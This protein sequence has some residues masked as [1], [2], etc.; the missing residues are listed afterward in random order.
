MNASVRA[1]ELRALGLRT[2]LFEAGPES[3]EEAVVFIHGGPGSANDWDDLLPRVGTFARAVAFDLPG[4]GQADK[5]ADWWG[6]S[7]AGWANFIGAALN[8]LGVR[9]A[10]LVMHD[11]GGEAACLWA[12]SNP[13]A[14]A[15]GVLINTGVPIGYRWHLIGRLHRIPLLGRVAMAT[16][17][18]GFPVMRLYEPRLPK[19]VLGR[20]RREYGWG[21]RRAML[22]F[23]R[24]NPRVSSG[25]IAPELRELD[26]PARVIWGARN[27]FVPVEQA[28][29]QLESFPSAEVVVVED[30]GHYTHLDSPER[31]AELVVPFLRQQVSTA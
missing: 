21:T 12:A 4:F 15:S 30:S 25:R 16:G 27:R 22:R 2:R 26:R 24:A 19:Q 6:Y 31:V 28:E 29:R 17:G 13:E 7:G 20:F 9:R 10:H 3:G 5:P 18:I 14:F 23:Y 11:L 1:G 8:R